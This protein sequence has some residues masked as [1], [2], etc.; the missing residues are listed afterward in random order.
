MHVPLQENCE[1]RVDGF[2]K[3]VD[4]QSHTNPKCRE[5][6]NPYGGCNRPQLHC[7]TFTRN[8]LNDVRK[9][10]GSMPYDMWLCKVLEGDPGRRAVI[11]NALVPKLYE[12]HCCYAKRV[13]V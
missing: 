10:R 8:T 5:L 2:D 12:I 9:G 3:Q 13:N 11:P 1:M 7:M 4:S 6:V